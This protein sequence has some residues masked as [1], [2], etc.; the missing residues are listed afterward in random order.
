[1]DYATYLQNLMANLNPDVQAGMMGGAVQAPQGF[2]MPQPTPTYATQPPTMPVQPSPMSGRP[3]QSQMTPSYQTPAAPIQP[4]RELTD[5]E[6]LYR[7]VLGR[8][9]DTGGS[10][11][12]TK[13][14][15]E[16]GTID[17][18]ERKTFEQAALP[19]IELT[20]LYQD[21]LGRAPD[22][23]GFEY[24]NKQF[25]ADGV[26]DENERKTFEEAARAELLQRK[27]QRDIEQ[28]TQETAA[29]TNQRMLSTQ[30][31]MRPDISSVMEAMQAA[32]NTQ[33]G[34]LAPQRADLNA[35]REQAFTSYD[36]K[37]KEEAAAAEAEAVKKSAEAAG[38]TAFDYGRSAGD[39]TGLTPEQIAFLEAE[40][41]EERDYRMRQIN[42]FLTP[43]YVTALNNKFGNYES[44]YGTTT[45]NS[46][47]SSAEK[48]GLTAA[49]SSFGYGSNKDFFGD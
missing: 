34:Y 4:Q 31:P 5:I 2:V 38:V 18:T 26:L 1:M 9:P 46:S 7:D 10:D 41:P 17:A 35:I 30:N 27:Q 6:K 22:S 49:Q 44:S 43:G 20:K 11:Y 29:V 45:A 19:E 42:Q 40:S 37:K 13:Q 12:W 24:W 36:T 16:D 28:K 48:A 33:Q 3:M 32:R 14:F 47:L 39:Y 15:L 23:A 25:M 21:V 8:A